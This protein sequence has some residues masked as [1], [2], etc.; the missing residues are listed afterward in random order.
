M[1]EKCVVC[2][3]LCSTNA[4]SCPSCGHPNPTEQLKSLTYRVEEKTTSWILVICGVV[5]LGWI[6]APENKFYILLML[7]LSAVA[8]IIVFNFLIKCAI[9]WE[10]SLGIILAA[11][12]MIWAFVSYEDKNYFHVFLA[13]IFSLPGFII[14]LKNSDLK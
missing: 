6:F 7:G 13:A 11:P 5:F 14:Y 3:H 9:N 8:L 1:Q 4:I 2:G 12:F 10:R